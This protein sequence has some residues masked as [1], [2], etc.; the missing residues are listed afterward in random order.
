MRRRVQLRSL[1]GVVAL[2]CACSGGAGAPSLDAADVADVPGPP[3]I[4]VVYA[5]V[6]VFTDAPDADITSPDAA[7]D[8][9]FDVT[10]DATADVTAD[11]MADP[12][13]DPGGE[14]VP[15][16]VGLSGGWGA[17]G[18]LSGGGIRVRVSLG[19][20]RSWILVPKA[21]T[22]AGGNE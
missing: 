13:A 4:D 3:P 20:V 21:G 6:P 17:G 19:S 7:P 11:S 18:V 9:R 16:P 12:G 2:L 5:D 8:V 1:A 15:G 14:V 10:V 22:G